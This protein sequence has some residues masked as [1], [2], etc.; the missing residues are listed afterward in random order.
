MRPFENFFIQT[1]LLLLQPLLLPQPLSTKPQPTQWL[2][3]S[4]LPQW[5]LLPKL[6]P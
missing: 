5:L 6:H 1:P 4:L 3:L 2:K